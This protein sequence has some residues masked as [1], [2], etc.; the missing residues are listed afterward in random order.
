MRACD[1]QLA[2]LTPLGLLQFFLQLLQTGDA[3]LQHTHKAP[4][5]PRADDR[6]ARGRFFLAAG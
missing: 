6:A 2:L 1:L 4:E 5:L 3:H